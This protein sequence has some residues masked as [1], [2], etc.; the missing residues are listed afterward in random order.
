[1]SN[2]ILGFLIRLMGYY[3]L[4]LAG[5]AI[6]GGV[7]TF[8][9]FLKVKNRTDTVVDYQ[10]TLRGKV[11]Y[12]TVWGKDRRAEGPLQLRKFEDSNVI[13]WKYEGSEWSKETIPSEIADM[14][15]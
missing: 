6:V 8:R 3:F 7:I 11:E 10:T 9:Y 4:I 13:E 5:I 14:F 15:Y 12:K 2:H 1:M